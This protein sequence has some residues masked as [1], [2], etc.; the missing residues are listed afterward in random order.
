MFAMERSVKTFI[1]LAPEVSTGLSGTAFCD[2]TITVSLVILLSNR[3]K[4][5][6]KET[7]SLIKGLVRFNIETGFLT[8][9][10]ALVELVLFHTLPKS[11]WYIML[12]HM[13]GGFYSNTFM[14]TLNYRAW[15][16]AEQSATQTVVIPTSMHWQHSAFWDDHC[17]SSPVDHE[18]GNRSSSLI[19]AK[20]V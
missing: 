15:I 5:G 17:D 19:L 14:A 11:T 20:C 6:L 1:E 10:A 18:L 2:M 13:L 9:I 7:T 16:S 3:K 8:S 4:K 12:F